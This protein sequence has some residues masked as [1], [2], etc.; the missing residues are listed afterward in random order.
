MVIRPAILG[1]LQWRTLSKAARL[2]WLVLAV[3][4]NKD[5]AA[6]F[7]LRVIA[8]DAGMHQ[9]TLLA[10]LDELSGGGLLTREKSQRWFAH[11]ATTYRLPREIPDSYPEENG[12]GSGGA[13]PRS[14]PELPRRNRGLY[15]LSTEKKIVGEVCDHP[16]HLAPDSLA[17]AEGKGHTPAPWFVS[18]KIATTGEHSAYIERVRLWLNGAPGDFWSGLK[19]DYPDTDPQTEARRALAWLKANPNKRKSRVGRYFTGWIARTQQRADSRKAVAH[20]A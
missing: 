13:T 12:V 1:S 2:V 10:A 17:N 4:A 5:G 8:G 9:D 18:A 14:S 6:R 7:T 11:E 15:R 19:G 20:A 16:R 3:R